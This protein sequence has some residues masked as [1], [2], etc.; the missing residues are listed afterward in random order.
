[1]TREPNQASCDRPTIWVGHVF[2]AEL[3]RPDTLFFRR[4]L[5]TPYRWPMGCMRLRGDRVIIIYLTNRV[6]EIATASWYL[7]EYFF[8][9]IEK[10]TKAAGSSREPAM[11]KGRS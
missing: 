2:E 8:S 4:R 10:L 9:L 11:A 7:A 6:G 1:M 3:H 5:S